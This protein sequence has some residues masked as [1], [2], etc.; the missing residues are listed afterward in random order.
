[1]NTV[2]PMG[3]R[4]CWLNFKQISKMLKMILFNTLILV[5]SS[6]SGKQ[7]KHICKKCLYIRWKLPILCCYC[8]VCCLEVC[9][10]QISY[11][12]PFFWT[13][14]DFLP[15]LGHHT[16]RLSLP[17]QTF[18]AQMNLMQPEGISVPF[19]SHWAIFCTDNWTFI[20]H[21]GF[22]LKGDLTSLGQTIKT[23]SCSSAIYKVF[24]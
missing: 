23:P 13:Y 19:S 3:R 16:Y 6:K 22:S 11:L 7:S 8:W 20:R 12:Y 21:A 9:S 14:T 18:Q 4:V 2:H 24:H 10:C 1:M 5:F 15:F 17:V